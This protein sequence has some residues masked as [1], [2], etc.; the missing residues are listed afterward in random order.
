MDVLTGEVAPG[1]APRET[2]G[3]LERESRQGSISLQSGNSDIRIGEYKGSHVAVR[4][5]TRKHVELNRALKK[6][7]LARREMNHEN[8]N[9]FIGACIESNR[10]CIVSQFCVR[11]SLYVRNV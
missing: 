2:R 9:R 6:D 11:R 7:L 10:V 5:V 4:H 3:L 1:D 8:I